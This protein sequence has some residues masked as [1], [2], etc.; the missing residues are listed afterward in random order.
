MVLHWNVVAYSTAEEYDLSSLASALKRQD[1]YYL[2][3]LTNDDILYSGLGNALHAIA[4]Y[5]VSNEN[6]H[7]YYFQ[8]GTVVIWNC[9]EIEQHAI[10]DF[11][12]PFELKDYDKHVVLSEIEEMSF[13]YEENSEKTFIDNGIMHIGTKNRSNEDI[14]SDRYTLSNAMALSVKLGILETLLNQYIQTIEPVTQELRNGLPVSI[15]QRG[16]LRKSGE[17]FVLRHSVSLSMDFLDI[18]DFYWDR[19]NL[20]GLY[21]LSCAYF[22]ITRR[23]KVLNEKLNHCLELITLVSTHLSDRHHVRLEW[24]IIILIMVEV[25]FEVLH[26]MKS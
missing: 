15:T 13:A 7:I 25:G 8:E 11:I 10:V 3:E 19:E 21:N 18:P 5:K 23:T 12:R 24:M 20:E 14:S 2:C 17:L 16:V 4:K 22:S 9:S 6:R 26:F 1:L